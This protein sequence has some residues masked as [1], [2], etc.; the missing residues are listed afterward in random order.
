MTRKQI[1][2][3]LEYKKDTQLTVIIFRHKEIIGDPTMDI[4]SRVE[5]ERVVSRDAE[6][7]RFTQLF[8][9]LRFSKQPK[10]NFFMDW[11]ALTCHNVLNL[12]CCVF[13]V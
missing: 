10:A 5:G 4:L 13:K 1:S 8:Q 9:I 7:Y 12:R 6:L 2:E 3:A 11:A